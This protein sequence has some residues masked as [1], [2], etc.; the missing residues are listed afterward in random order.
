MNTIERRNLA[1]QVQKNKEDILKHFQRDEILADFGI[2]I[3]GTVSS[4]EELEAIPTAGLQYGDAYAVGTKSPYN[5]YIWT[6]A[7]NVSQTDYWFNFGEIAIAGPAGPQ[8]ARGPRGI[9]G[10]STRWY[11]F[12]DFDWPSDQY[13]G[14]YNDGDMVLDKNGDV[15]MYSTGPEWVRVTNIKGAIGRAG[16]PGRKGDPGLQGP[17]GPKGDKGDPGG[18]VSIAGILEEEEGLPDPALVDNKS[19]GYLV[20]TEYPYDLYIQVGDP[21]RY[22]VNTGPLN[23]AS[24]ISIDGQYVNLWDADTK[25]DRITG[26][27]PFRNENDELPSVVYTQ[28]NGVDEWS[29]YST[30]PK[31]G[32]FALWTGPSDGPVLK[33]GTPTENNH[34]ANKAYVDDKL[35]DIGTNHVEII[36][37]TPESRT[38]DSTIRN[39]LFASAQYSKTNLKPDPK[40]LYAMRFPDN[41]SFPNG[42]VCYPINSTIYTG[43]MD[44]REVIILN[45]KYINIEPD[46]PT[47]FFY[48]LQI[49]TCL[50]DG[51]ISTTKYY[52]GLEPLLPDTIT[53][54]PE[55]FSV[56]NIP[57]DT[58]LVGTFLDYDTYPE[59]CDMI[60]HIAYA[61]DESYNGLPNYLFLCAGNMVT[62]FRSVWYEDEE[63]YLVYVCWWS[64]QDETHLNF[65]VRFYE[66]DG[67]YYLDSM[68]IS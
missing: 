59:F 4:Q 26:L 15:Y 32:A 48:H 40:R 62:S 58:R 34:V 67:T 9:D 6:R 13:A 53:E 43:Y 52:S 64:S 31:T 11:Y 5:Y 39:A 22:W 49:T 3:I 46:D 47:Q 36:Y 1:E 19:I 41:L 55:Y 63:Y 21:E 20:G 38:W 56:P 50:D 51:N 23:A 33:S 25:R 61:E 16:A 18:F 66:N 42:M 44:Y 45:L 27:E 68:Y 65:A 10:K 57:D 30:E 35:R 29:F 8:G 24:L 12:A 7:N 54:R 14:N 17:Q 2:R 28:S 37:L 60:L